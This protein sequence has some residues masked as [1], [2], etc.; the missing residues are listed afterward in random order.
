MDAFGKQYA[1]FALQVRPQYEKIVE[2]CL[3]RKG[4]EVLLPLY[5]CRKR[6]SDRIKVL[7]LPLFPTY[8]FCR[9]DINMRLPVLSTS[10][11]CRA[12]GI[13]KTPYPVDDNEIAAI[14]AVVDS[15][16]GVLPCPSFNLGQRIRIELGPLAGVEGTLISFR[17]RSRMVVSV[18][19]LQRAVAV[20]IDITWATPVSSPQVQTFPCVPQQ[21]LSHGKC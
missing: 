18:S 11:V 8:L 7:E 17:G 16:L 15:G 1:W 6:W 4:Y 20:E 9:F 12:V 14:R 21:H 19:L 3:L 2:S 13:G 5:R 10:G